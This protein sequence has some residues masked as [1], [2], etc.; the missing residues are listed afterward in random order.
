MTPVSAPVHST[1]CARNLDSIFIVSASTLA[2]QL[3]PA[4]VE[5]PSDPRAAA[6]VEARLKGEALSRYPGAMP[7][8]IGEAYA[9]QQAA[10]C[11]WPDKIV[12]WKVGRINPP[13]DAEFGTDRLAGPIF[14]RDMHLD[15]GE[16]TPVR[17][18]RGGFGAVEGELI[19][20]A[21]Q[22]APAGKTHWTLDDARSMAGAMHLGFE[23]ASSPFAGI[24]DHGPLVTISDFGNNCGLILGPE[25]ESGCVSDPASLNLRMSIDSEVVGEAAASSIPGGPMESFRALLGICAENGSPIRAGMLISTGAVTG[26]HTIKI[27]QR[28]L[29]T[30]LGMEMRCR[31]VAA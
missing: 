6:F 31:I 21:A 9:L 15:R 10:I 18:F 30:G 27:G 8:T 20:V 13:W 4:T 17:V 14:A 16:E 11:A 23:I 3:F 24:N 2:D 5:R 1:I 26:V 7:T 22:D 12:G 28:A 29:L 25:I 19:I